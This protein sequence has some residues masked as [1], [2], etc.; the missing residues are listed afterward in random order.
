MITCEQ[1]GRPRLAGPRQRLGVAHISGG[2]HVARLALG[3]AIPQFPRRA[4]NRFDW[5]TVSGRI[6]L[7]DVRHRGAQ[8]SRSVKADRRGIGGEG[9]RYTH[10]YAADDPAPAA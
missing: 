5:R 3:Q 10:D 1:H 7:R 9:R 8:A 6:R 4:E 2:E